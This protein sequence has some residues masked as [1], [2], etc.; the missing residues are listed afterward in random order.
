MTY[1]SFYGIVMLTFTDYEFFSRTLSTLYSQTYTTP[2]DV[3]TL[4]TQNLGKTPKVQIITRKF[5]EIDLDFEPKKYH[6][7]HPK[8]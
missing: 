4:V 3:C 6:F 1:S 2:D 8:K 5:A 7:D